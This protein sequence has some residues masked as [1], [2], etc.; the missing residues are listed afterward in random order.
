MLPAAFRPPET[1]VAR[2]SEPAAWLLVPL[3]RF[4]DV[5]SLKAGRRRPTDHL[6]WGLL[7]LQSVICAELPAHRVRWSRLGVGVS[8]SPARFSLPHRPRT[9]YAIRFILSCAFAPLQSISSSAC[10]VPH[11]TKRLPWGST[12]LRDIDRRSPHS[13]RLP[14]PHFVPPSAFL[15]PSTACSSIGLAGLFHPA[16]TSRIRSSGVFPPAQ[17]SEL[18]ARRALVPVDPIPLPAFPQAP[19]TSS[20]AFRACLRAGIRRD[21]PGVSRSVARSPLEFIL[22]RVLLCAP[23]RRL[24]STPPPPTAFHGPRRVADAQPA[25]LLRAKL[26]RSRFPACRYRRGRNAKRTASIAEPP[27]WFVATQPSHCDGRTNGRPNVSA[28]FPTIGRRAI[29]RFFGH[30]LWTS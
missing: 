4:G 30:S 29:C 5:F 15:T 12:P 18:V 25:L 8:T 28:C 23:W 20:P 27:F 1:W 6:S 24:W 3:R 26:P 16:A 14:R 2:Q 9:T 22:P 11:D 7:A 21:T 10:L 13:R 17:P 19:G